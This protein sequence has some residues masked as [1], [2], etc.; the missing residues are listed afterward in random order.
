MARESPPAQVVLAQAGDQ[1]PTIA[2]DGDAVH[3]RAVQAAAQQ[4]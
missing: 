3:S 2:L 1:P 4:P